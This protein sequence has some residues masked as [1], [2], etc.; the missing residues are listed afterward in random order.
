MRCLAAHHHAARAQ[1]VFAQDVLFQRPARLLQCGCDETVADVG[2]AEMAFGRCAHSSDLV[3][4]WVD[5]RVLAALRVWPKCYQ[6]Q[7]C[8]QWHFTTGDQ[9]AK[10][11][12]H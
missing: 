4:G 12:G 3:V 10:R 8:V 5:S 6:V 7:Q 2:F 11:L 9:D 1:G